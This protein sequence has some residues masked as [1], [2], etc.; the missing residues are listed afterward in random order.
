MIGNEQKRS[1]EEMGI[2]RTRMEIDGQ[3]KVESSTCKEFE[4]DWRM[5]A[6]EIERRDLS[7]RS[8]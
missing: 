1:E 4:R 6:P 8:R 3:D 7:L 5:G 2:K